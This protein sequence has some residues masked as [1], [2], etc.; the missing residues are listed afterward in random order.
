MIDVTRIASRL[1]RGA[2]TG[3]DRVELAYIRY[4]PLTGTPVLALLRTK[5]GVM[6]LRPKAMAELQAWAGGAPIPQKRD[7]LAR[8][9]RRHNTVLARVETALRRFAITRAPMALAG[10]ALRGKLGN[11]AVYFNTGHANLSQQMMRALRAVPGLR[12]AVLVH[13]TIPL[14]HPMFSRPDQIAG[15]ARK[16]QAV[17][18]HADL[19]IHTSAATRILTEAQLARLGRVPPGVVSALGVSVVPPDGAALPKGLNLRDPYFLAI[20]TIEPRKNHA[21]LLDVWQAM[22]ARGGPLP[23]LFILGN[24]G[25]ADPALFARL[26]AGVP[27]VTVLTGLTDGAMSALLR[28]ARALLFPSLVEGFG[29]PPFE[30]AALGTPVISTPLP[31]IR[32]GLGD[33]PVYLSPTDSYSWI[34]TITRL[35]TEADL[36]RR[37]ECVVPPNWPDH[38]KTVLKAL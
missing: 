29:L 22:A 24:R 9:T 1:A 10:R 26:D 20:G 6:L 15:F 25:W 32:E 17:A 7:L 37:K 36:A 35:T 11:S 31:P 33:Y 27:G 23:H 38:F 18:D 2:M 19:V 8:L 13:D 34:E 5:A 3:I 12:I 30:A 28:G 14:D 16:M 4:I 21:L